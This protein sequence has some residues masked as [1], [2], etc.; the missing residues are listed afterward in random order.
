MGMNFVQT[1][2]VSTYRSGKAGRMN[3]TYFAFHCL[4][5]LLHKVENAP[6][7]RRVIV[8]VTLTAPRPG[9]A[10]SDISIASFF[11]FIRRLTSRHLFMC[12]KRRV[13]VV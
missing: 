1:K 12:R 2:T 8:R 7:E 13:A 10:A 11:V 3:G 5:S 4:E 6:K 9:T